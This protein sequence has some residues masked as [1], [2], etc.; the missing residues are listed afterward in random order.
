ML[1]EREISDPYPTLPKYLLI[2]QYDSC[3]L[4]HIS[5]YKIEHKESLKSLFVSFKLPAIFK[6]VMLSDHHVAYAN[7]WDLDYEV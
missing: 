1:N 5:D 2:K 4:K 7:E 3:V 6:E